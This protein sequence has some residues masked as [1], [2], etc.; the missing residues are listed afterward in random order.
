MIKIINIHNLFFYIMKNLIF[1]NRYECTNRSLAFIIQVR[2]EN[3]AQTK[4]RIIK[5]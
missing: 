5:S 1:R 2:T 4:H 3:L